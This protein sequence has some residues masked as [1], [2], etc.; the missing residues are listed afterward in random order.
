MKMASDSCFIT[1]IFI[2]ALLCLLSQLL[3]FPQYFSLTSPKDLNNEVELNSLSFKSNSSL[4]SELTYDPVIRTLTTIPKPNY[5]LNIYALPVG[6]GDC[7]IVQCP[8][9]ELIIIDAGNTGGEGWMEA[10]IATFLKP[11]LG[12]ISTLIIM[13]ADR[14]HFSYIPELFTLNDVPNLQRIILGG[15]KDDYTSP[16]FRK[17]LNQ[18]AEVVEYINNG[19][20]CIGK[21]NNDPPQCNSGK[22]GVTFR[23]LGANLGNS[24]DGRSIMMQIVA[25]PKFQMLLPGDFLGSDIEELLVNEWERRGQPLR[26]THLKMSHHGNSIRANS[27]VF[28]SA[29]APSFAFASASYPAP[30]EW[31]PS[32]ESIKTLLNVGSIEL[33]RVPGRFSC[34]DEADR[35][36]IQ[37]ENWPY[38]IYTLSP[39]IGDYEMVT[40][41]VPMPPRPHTNYSHLN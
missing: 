41:N 1:L 36:A 24:V 29:V 20:P 21:C 5:D 33:R 27:K 18:H 19:E 22:D 2:I 28:L 15:R 40:I 30:P 17:W 23:Y 6:N 34:G 13:H 35:K 16:P 4:R 26:S 12:K 11:Q 37:Y 7:T 9:G 25:G 14:D 31:Y 38:S 8:S 3:L 39:N 10:M 32:C